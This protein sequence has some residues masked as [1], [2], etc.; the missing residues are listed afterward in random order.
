[1]SFGEPLLLLGLLLLPALAYAYVGHERRTRQRSAEAFVDPALAAAVMPRR[2][3]W[4]RHVPV[5]LQALA[6]TALILALAKPQTTKAVPV[7]QATVVVVTDRSGSMEAKD[8][9]PSRLV[10]AR[11]A[12][13]TFVDTVPE[14][15][16]VG[17]IAFNQ[18]ATVLASPTRDH[19]AVRTALGTVTAAGSTA[20]GDALDAALGLIAR[21]PGATDAQA[22]EAQQPPA[23]IVLLSDGKSVRGQDV[24]EVAEKARR[25]KVPVYTVALGTPTGTITGSDGQVRNVPPDVT[26]LQQV[27]E[28]TGGKAFTSDDAEQLEQVYQRLGSQLATENQDVEQ[29]SLFAGGAFVLL[30]L[31]AVASI[32]WFGRLV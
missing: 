9:A 16:R 21:T 11:R 29:S 13:Q 27:A 14:R 5:V 28:T 1:M 7:E 20:T 4:R 12:A 23:A 6:V 3:R 25:A 15:F 24:L 32:R 26:T 10:A 31:G 2:P 8:V 30:L 17:A 19:D 22:P 18:Q